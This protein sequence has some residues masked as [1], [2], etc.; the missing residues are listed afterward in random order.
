MST[1]GSPSGK[2]QPSTLA[3]RETLFGDM[4]VNKWPGDGADATIFPWTAFAAARSHLAAGN[5]DAAMGFWKQVL[6]NPKLESRFHLQAWHFLKQHGEQPSSDIA[7]QLLGVVIEVSMPEGLDLLAAYPDYSARYYNYSGG[8]VVW[9]HPDT[10]LDALIAQLLTAAKQVVDRIGP[11]DKPRPAAPPVGQ[12]RM[13][14]LT[15]IGLHFG[16]GPMDV[17]LQDQLGAPVI[18]SG[19]ALMKAMIAKTNEG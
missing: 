10:S 18:H 3:I 19:I 4:P 17:M 7:K 15:P 11:W 1:P 9:E 2:K 6:A 12:V 14:F 5:K 13:N 16:Q 8:G